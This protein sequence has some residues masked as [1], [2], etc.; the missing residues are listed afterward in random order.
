MPCV[1]GPV[2][3]LIACCLALPPPRHRLYSIKQIPLGAVYFLTCSL[4]L[5]FQPS[6]HRVVNNMEALSLGVLIVSFQIGIDKGSCSTISALDVAQSLPFTGT[7]APWFAAGLLLRD[8]TGASSIALS[9]IVIFAHVVYVVRSRLAGCCDWPL[10]P[11]CG[12]K[13]H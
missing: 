10:T 13:Y 9:A 7:H 6:E 1:I 3:C 12:N 8:A 4:Q 2:A 5:T 11:A